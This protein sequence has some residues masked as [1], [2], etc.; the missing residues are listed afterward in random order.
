[1]LKC[2]AM[3]ICRQKTK[4]KQSSNMGWNCNR[5]SRAA[6]MV[7]HSLQSPDVNNQEGLGGSTGACVCFWQAFWSHRLQRLTAS[8]CL[9]PA[10]VQCTSCHGNS[11][12]FLFR[13]ITAPNVKLHRCHTVMNDKERSRHA[14]YSLHRDYHRRRELH[15][16]HGRAPSHTDIHIWALCH[17]HP[18][19]G[20]RGKIINQEC[21]EA[22]LGPRC[23]LK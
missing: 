22:K 6:P 1:M 8:C 11:K 21:P 15:T 14:Y 19:Q 23:H 4:S 9:T 13:C 12:D 10:R 16:W 20:P 3:T 5:K 2:S 7:M 17:F 18:R